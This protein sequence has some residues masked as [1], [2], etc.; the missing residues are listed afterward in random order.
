MRAHSLTPICIFD[1]EDGRAI[2]VAEDW[3]A[4]APASGAGFRW[5]HLDLSDPASADWLHAHIPPVAA[6]ALAQAET[7]P[8]CDPLADGILL[9]L[10]GVNLNPG[11]ARE[12]MVSLRLWVTPALVV[13]ARIRRIRATDELRQQ[14]DSGRGPGSVALF[15]SELLHGLSHRIETVSLELDDRTDGIEE[16][17]LQGAGDMHDRLSALRLTVIKLRRYLHPQREAL[18][19]L[20]RNEAGLFDSAGL[21]LLREAVDRTRRTIEELDATRDRLAAVQDQIAS[22]QVRLLG[23][24]SFVLSV[25]AAVFLPLGFL[26]GLFG[27]NIAGMPGTGTP[28]AFWLLAGASAL[29]GLAIVL[30]FRLLKW[31]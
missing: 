2:P 15:L 9:N 3:P 27:V 14:S 8:R 28:L 23:R 10:R 19:A 16:E 6:S 25:V 22:E 29:L 31:L 13:T 4:A 26:T 21:V 18:D 5:L 12:D 20:L 24:N 11:S 7:R 17:A 30:L 1:F